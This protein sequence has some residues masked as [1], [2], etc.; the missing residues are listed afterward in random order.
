MAASE[1]EPDR[2]NDRTANVR[3]HASHVD[4]ASTILVAHAQPVRLRKA[5]FH[6]RPPPELAF[7]AHL[8]V[9]AFQDGESAGK[10]EPAASALGRKERFE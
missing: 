3:P 10:T 2:G 7:D 8:R 1:R 4:E 5:H 6:L 9:V